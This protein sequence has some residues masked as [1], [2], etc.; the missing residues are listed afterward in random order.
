MVALGPPSRSPSIPF[1]FFFARFFSPRGEANPWNV[2]NSSSPYQPNVILFPFLLFSPNFF[3]AAILGDVVGDSRRRRRLPLIHG[4]AGG[5]HTQCVA[6]QPHHWWVFPSFPAHSLLPQSFP[7]DL[8]S[9]V[10]SPPGAPRLQSQHRRGPP[11]PCLLL[12]LETF[13]PR[14]F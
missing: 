7:V 8:A 4:V 5:V 2:L 12:L 1:L 14:L 11:L 6:P 10:A 13:F 3:L 9:P